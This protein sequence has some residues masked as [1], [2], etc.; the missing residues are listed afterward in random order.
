[1]NN[2]IEVYVN[3]TGFSKYQISNF[4]NCKNIKT[5]RILKPGTNCNGY[6][7]VILMDDGER[8]TKT[9]HRLVANAFLQ[10][11]EDKK[12]VDHVDRNK[13]NNYLSNLRY[14]TLSENSQNASMKSNNTSGVVGVSWDKNK[15]KW[16]VQ[17]TVN[18]VQKHLGYFTIKEDAIAARTTAEIQ[19]FGEFRAIIPI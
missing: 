12:N 17:I 13:T 6:L 11:S 10:N 5:G 3:I 9:I 18:C 4:G 19:Y 15:N 14:A 8:S 2:N 1:M 7:Y 16:K